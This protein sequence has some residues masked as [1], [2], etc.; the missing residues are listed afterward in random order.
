METHLRMAGP[1]SPSHWVMKQVS[2]LTGHQA[3]LSRFENPQ[4]DPGWY[5]PDSVIW[6][7]HAHFVAMM[8]GG[9]GSLMLQALHPRALAAVWDH[10]NFRHDLTGRL[11][12]TAYFIAATTF[13]PEDLAQEVIDRVNRIH[14]QIRGIMPDG[15]TYQ[16]NEPELVEWVHMAEVHCFLQAYQSLSTRPLGPVE[17]N[18]YLREVGRSG[19][20]LGARTVPETL[21]ELASGLAARRSDLQID[22]RTRQTHAWIEALPRQSPQTWLT[23]AMVTQALSTLPDWALA[24]MG[25]SQN[26]ANWQGGWRRRMLLALGAAL[27]PTLLEQGVAGVARRRVLAD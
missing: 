18:R 2:A 8:V 16:A 3:D 13:G 10:S 11:G 21:D 22:E 17:A 24:L 19:L 14:A 27:Q 20:A 12:R 26:E 6:Q 1:L 15:R 23:Q 7:V 9:I 5:G 25:R 4:G